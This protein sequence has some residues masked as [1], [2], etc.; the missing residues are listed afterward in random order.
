LI[1][2]MLSDV[3]MP[4]ISGFEVAEMVRENRPDIKVVFMSGYPNRGQKKNAVIPKYAQFLQKPVNAN[5][6]AHVIRC[7]IEGT[8]LP[9]VG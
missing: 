6:L 4:S 2:V 9:L 8:K 5:H 3:V 1:D 7:E